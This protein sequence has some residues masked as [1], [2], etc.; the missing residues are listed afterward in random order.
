MF[1]E[2]PKGALLYLRVPGASWVGFRNSIDHY[3]LNASSTESDM[4]FPRVNC[5]HTKVREA[6]VE[7]KDRKFGRVALHGEGLDRFCQSLLVRWQYCL[8]P[9][10]G[11]SRLLHGLNYQDFEAL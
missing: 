4:T 7:G 2:G 11:S 8:A 3:S 6:V 9:P 1:G 5:A 10:Q